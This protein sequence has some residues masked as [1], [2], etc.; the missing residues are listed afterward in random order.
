LSESQSATHSSNSTDESP[1]VKQMESLHPEGEVT[2][3]WLDGHGMPWAMRD[4]ADSLLQSGRGFVLNLDGADGQGTHWV[5]ARRLGDTLLYA[6][7][8]GSQYFNGYPPKELNKFP[9]RVVSTKA[10]QHPNTDYCGYYA[11]LFAKKMDGLTSPP[12]SGAQLS[13]ALEFN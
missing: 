6:D 1:I 8:F 3:D 9:H 13:R 5:A 4:N 12:S 2:S 10:F 11:Y 7:P